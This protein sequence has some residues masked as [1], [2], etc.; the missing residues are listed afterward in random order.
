MKTSIDRRLALKVF[1]AVCMISIFVCVIVNGAIDNR[2]TWSAYPILSIPFV[3]LI[4]SPL[5][6]KK[7]GIVLSLC[8][9]ML[10]ILPFLYL[11]EKITPVDGWFIPLG[12]P[13]AVAGMITIWIIYLLFRFIRI[14]LWYKSAI[15]VFFVGIIT[16]PVVNHYVDEYLNTGP[17]VLNNILNIASFV[18]VSAAIAI[19]GYRKNKAKK[20]CF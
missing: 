12:F 13:S 17:S 1:S 16:S 4:I 6:V 7:H 14:S 15:A 20:T 9:L 3:W 11:L 5:T 10:F 19:L 8:S 2:I 18:I